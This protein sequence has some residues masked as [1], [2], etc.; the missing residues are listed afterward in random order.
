[1]AV[2]VRKLI[3]LMIDSRWSKKALGTN[4]L[5]RVLTGT[6]ISIIGASCSTREAMSTLATYLIAT[7]I[8]LPKES[9]S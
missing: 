5:P 9:A 4:L 8:V 1:M 7:H 6:V 3:R 2:T